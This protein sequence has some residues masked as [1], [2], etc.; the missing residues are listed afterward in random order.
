M[1]TFIPFYYSTH[2]IITKADQGEINKETLRER[3]SDR[4]NEMVFFCKIDRIILKEI[5]KAIK[6]KERCIYHMLASSTGKSEFSQIFALVAH[7]LVVKMMVQRG[8]KR[9]LFLFMK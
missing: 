5:R 7:D 8:G 4:E 6:Q 9:N 1:K 3:E 2:T